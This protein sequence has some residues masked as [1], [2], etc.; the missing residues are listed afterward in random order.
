M[1]ALDKYH[2][3][4]DFEFVELTDSENAEIEGGFLPILLAAACL[5]LVSSCN[6]K[7]DVHITVNVQGGSHNN[8]TNLNHAD[9]TSHR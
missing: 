7:V 1:L 4:G 9:S 8:Q 6:N 5:L 3:Y 2:P